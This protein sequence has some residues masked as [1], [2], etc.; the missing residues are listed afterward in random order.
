MAIIPQ[1]TDKPNAN[2]I[3]GTMH[4]FVSYSDEAAAQLRNEILSLSSKVPTGGRKWYVSPD[5]DDDNSGTTPED[6]F[7]T[8][9]AIRLHADDISEGDSVLFARGG[10]YRGNIVAKSG[11]Y[12]GAYGEG[13]KPCVYVSRCNYAQQM[14]TETTPCHW[15]ITLPDSNDVGNVIF[16]HGEVVGVKRRPTENL[17]YDLDFQYS[18]HVLH[19]YSLRNPAERFWSIEISDLNHIV[20]IPTNTQDVTVENLT[21]KYGGGHGI[22]ALDGSKNITIRGCEIGFVGGSYLPGHGEGYTRFGNGVEFWQG[23]DTVLVENCWI[24]QIYDSGLS[25]QGRGEFEAKHVTFHRNLIEYTSFAS[26]EYWMSD[27][28]G[29]TIARHIRYTDNILRF[30]GY[31]WGEL[32]RP[33]IHAYHILATGDDGPH[34]CDDFLIEGNILDLSARCLVRCRSTSGTVPVLKGNTYYQRRNGLLGGYR[35]TAEPLARFDDDAEETLRTT[36][37]DTEATLRYY[38]GSNEI[39]I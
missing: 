31:G 37:G 18:D 38:D 2:V 36:F 29:K 14:W 11:V 32:W 12:Y 23:C 15:E 27:G 39:L 16:N 17:V 10:V 19:L 25:H 30:A 6:A 33:F 5:G 3:S 7:A 4:P 1:N 8:P 34:P 13:D 22:V 28:G 24:Y 21:L 26:I 35:D 9:M 20:L